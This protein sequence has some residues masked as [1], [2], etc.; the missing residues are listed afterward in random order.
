MVRTRFEDLRIYPLAEELSE[1]A[2]NM[3][4][5]WERFPRETIGRQV[6]DC[7]DSIGANIAE[8]AG[9]GT[10]ADNR[11]FARIARG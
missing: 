3:V 10:F 9:R 2:W 1:L 11:R 6:V 7:A 8:G 4:L 5:K